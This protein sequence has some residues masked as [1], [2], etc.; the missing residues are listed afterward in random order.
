M[1]RYFKLHEIHQFSVKSKNQA[2]VV[3]RFN[4]T[5]RNRM[6][7][8]FSYSNTHRWIEVLPNLLNA[9]NKSM[10]R[11]IQMAPKDVSKSNEQEIW[12]K[13]EK[14]SLPPRRRKKR[15]D[16]H[17]GMYV[18]VSKAKG[19]FEKGYTHNWTTEVFQI[20]EILNTTPVQV[21]LIDLNGTE[22]VGSWYLQEIQQ[23]NLPETYKIEKVLGQ[24]KVGRRKEYLVKWVG[25]SD[26]FN[27]W[28]PE[29]QMTQI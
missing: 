26:K 9:Y 4:R 23:V 5:L 2:A 25:Y 24:R 16:F 8:Y 7:R 17:V 15:N 27:Q 13:Q 12:L 19:T 21:K 10:H 1:Q 11:T 3:E 20:S 22:I 14:M 29:N 18:R 28:I 6:H